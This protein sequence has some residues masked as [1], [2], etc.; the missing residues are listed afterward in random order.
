MN[1]PVALDDEVVQL[2]LPL[3]QVARIGIDTE[4][5]RQGCFR[6]CLC[7]LKVGRLS[8]ELLVQFAYHGAHGLHANALGPFLVVG[9]ELTKRGLEIAE[10]G[11]QPQLGFESVKMEDVASQAGKSQPAEGL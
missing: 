7:G 11:E 1:Q 10:Q 8:I 2:L 6:D 9:S 3:V 5:D 4:P